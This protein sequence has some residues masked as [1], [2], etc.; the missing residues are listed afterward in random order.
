MTASISTHLTDDQRGHRAPII[1]LKNP[2]V[3]RRHAHS[4]AFA[5]SAPR[6]RSPR[7]AATKVGAFV[8]TDAEE[9]RAEV[10]RE[11]LESKPSELKRPPT[12]PA[13]PAKD[14]NANWSWAE[15]L[16]ERN[17]NEPTHGWMK[18]ASEEINENLSTLRELQKEAYA[19]EKEDGDYLRVAATSNAEILSF[20]SS[21][22]VLPKY[23]FPVDAVGLDLRIRELR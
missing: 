12:A 14:S 5:S 4:V 19:E 16:F 21:R 7:V 1:H 8:G 9:P 11:W 13:G 3:L 15:A 10:F 18:R 6:V 2:A 23:G 22:N 17:E 20:L